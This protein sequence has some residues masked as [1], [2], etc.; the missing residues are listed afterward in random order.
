MT[1]KVTTALRKLLKL[2]KRKKVIQGGSSAGKT[3]S[4]LPILIDKAI[5]V[6]GSEI[7]I[8][9]ESIPHLKRGA[10]KDFLKIMMSLGRFSESKLNKSEMKYTFSNGS[11]IEFFS[12]EQSDK[13]RGARRTDLYVNEANN[14]SFDSY[15][16]LA[17]RTSGDIWIDF[18]PTNRFW[19]H[20]EVLTEDDSELLKLT[21]KDNEALPQSIIDEI[22]IAKVKAEAGSDYWSNWWSVYGLGEIGSLMGACITEWSTI[23]KLPEGAKLLSVGLDFG[24]TNDPSSLVALYSYNG[25]YIADEILYKKGLH[26]VEIS[27]ILNDN[28]HLK[29]AMIFADS[30]EPKSIAELFS[31]GHN[32]EGV[33]KG[34]DS[35][36]YGINAINQNGIRVTSRSKNLITELQN[37][38]WKV[39]REGVTLN[40][41]VDAYNHCIDALRYAFVSMLENK[42]RGEYHIW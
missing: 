31:Y 24:F 12:V 36:V 17:M 13:L 10:Y 19:A 39:T 18:N 34:R 14:I 27:D 11:Y 5:K 3:F 40:I 9:S 23:D 28:P 21:Y 25:E 7:S 8:V 4:I 32:I 1:F 37:Y 33:K 16:Q 29:E 38:I 42:N 15:K 22:E 6:K 26:N 35:I 30:S 41:P 2:T 20:T